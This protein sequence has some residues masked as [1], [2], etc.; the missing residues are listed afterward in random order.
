MGE[1]IAKSNYQYRD[2][3][4]IS[5][6]QIREHID[7]CMKGHKSCSL[8]HLRPLMCLRVIDCEQRLVVDA[9]TDCRYITLSYVWGES[10][11]PKNF[12]LSHSLPPT[13]EHSI[14]TTLKLGYKYL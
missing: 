5:F 1:G 6:S 2:P 8:E 14:L 7:I 3:P 12:V 13:I 11:G 9:P 10:P 4:K